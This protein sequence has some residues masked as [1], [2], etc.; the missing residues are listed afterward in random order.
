[1][2]A[3]GKSETA[4]PEA[5]RVH[6][7]M[8]KKQNQLSSINYQLSIHLPSIPPSIYP[9]IHPFTQHVPMFIYP[10]IHHL[11][12]YVSMCSSI[13]LLV[14]LLIYSCVCIM[15][16]VSPS[17]HVS[18]HPSLLVHYVYP[19]V[20]HLSIYQLSICSYSYL[21]RCTVS[22]WLTQSWRVRSTK[23]YSSK[24]GSVGQLLLQFKDLSCRKMTAQMPTVS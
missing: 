19:P 24:A 11:H 4:W 3:S 10:T 12:I 2:Q 8:P 20:H 21:V 17:A 5:D 16:S 22:N 14:Y 13:S 23:T 18:I 6:Q 7:G 1:M 9:T 15:S